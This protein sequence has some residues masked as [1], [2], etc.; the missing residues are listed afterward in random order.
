MSGLKLA[1]THNLKHAGDLGWGPALDLESQSPP[2]PAVS[3][4]TWVS[5]AVP[6]AG[7]TDRLDLG[8][9]YRESYSNFVLKT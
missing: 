3:K 4:Q 2:V 9:R 5:Q 8:Y 6:K 7:R 1:I